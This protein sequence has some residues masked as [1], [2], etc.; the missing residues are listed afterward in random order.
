MGDLVPFDP[1]RS[2]RARKWTRPEDYIPRSFH[3]QP[4]PLAPRQRPRTDWRRML[5]AVAVWLVIAAAVAAG[6]LYSLWR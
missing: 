1:R 3:K 5:R 4:V 2:R 6:V